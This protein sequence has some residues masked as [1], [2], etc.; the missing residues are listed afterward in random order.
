MT[1]VEEERGDLGL[2]AN[3]GF[4][5]IIAFFTIIF[6]ILLKKKFSYGSREN[7][8]LNL[9][10][11]SE[12]PGK[13]DLKQIV[14]ILNKYCASVNMKRFDETNEVL[15]ASFLVEFRG[16][17]QIEKTKT[18]LRQLSESVKITF[19]DSRGTY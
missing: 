11:S 5:T 12:S 13:I 10:V 14:A 8:N 1:G 18:E 17:K 16:Y 7:Q 4:I 19:L 3:Q 6:A 9:T 2:G 15:E